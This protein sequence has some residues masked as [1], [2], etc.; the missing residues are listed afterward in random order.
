MSCLRVNTLLLIICDQRLYLM[1]VRLQ[2][3]TD[4]SMCPLGHAISSS[5]CQTVVIPE[6]IQLSK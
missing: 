3:Y 6:W 2:P 1:P 5:L 4:G